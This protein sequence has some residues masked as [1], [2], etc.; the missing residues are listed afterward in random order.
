MSQ[1]D[2]VHIMLSPFRMICMGVNADL[3]QVYNG[4]GMPHFV[5]LGL[6]FAQYCDS[7]SLIVQVF[8]LVVAGTVT[9]TFMAVESIFGARFAPAMI[10]LFVPLVVGLL[11]SCSHSIRVNKLKTL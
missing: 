1:H 8:L 3:C 2:F 9:A 5:A 11:H 7:R 4:D 6:Q 10:M